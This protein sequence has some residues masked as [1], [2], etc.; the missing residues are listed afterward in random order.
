MPEVPMMGRKLRID[1]GTACGFGAV[2]LWSMTVALVRSVSEQVGPLTAAASVYLVGGALC[3]VQL[4]SSGKT[5][6]YVR[7]LPPKYL[8]GCGA[9]FVVY[10]LLLYLAVGLAADRR[11]VLQVGLLNYF[12]PALTILFSLALLDKKGSLLLA[13]ATVLALA[14][15]FLVLTQGSQ[16]SWRGF[17]S[18]LARSPAAYSLA[19]GA[20]VSWALYSNLTRRWAGPQTPSAVW[21]FIPATGV[22]LVAVRILSAEHSEW[23]ARALS[24]AAVLGAATAAAYTLWDVAMRKGN[25]TAVA[26]FSYLTPLF[27]TIVGSVYLGVTPTVSLWVGCT[28]IIAGAL[29]SWASVSDKPRGQAA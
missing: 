5:V 2:L 29:L 3:L 27:S 22:V 24:E 21:M 7:S 8:F 6:R 4:A 28:L 23:T 12:W 14:G 17:A 11:Q 15:I 20:A 26:A 9:L 10:M 13:P 1:V 16:V 18:N 25:V 19:L